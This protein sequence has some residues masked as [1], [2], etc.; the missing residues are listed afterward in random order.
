M[1]KGRKIF[2]I[3]EAVLAVMV[4]LVAF[5]MLWERRGRNLDKISV[6]VENSDDTQWSAFKYGLRM[7]AEDNG[8][9][10]FFVSTG[11]ELTVEE[12]QQMIQT[13]IDNGADAVIVQP[14]PGAEEMLLKMER[15]IPVMLVGYAP[16]GTGASEFPAVGPD[17]YA[18][19]AA[20][21]EELLKDYEE[22]LEGRTLGLLL[23]STDSQAILDREQGFRDV[24]EKAG[25]SVVWSMESSALGESAEVIAAQ[26][27]VDCVAALDD[28]SLT[29]AGAYSSSNVLQEARVYGIGHSTEAAYYLD[30]GAVN[31][32]IVPDEF[33]VGYQSLTE[34]AKNLRELWYRMRGTTVSY[35]AIRREELF[36]KE[37]QEILFT[38]SQ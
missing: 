10:M 30:T 22:S 1:K 16:D 11:E 29:A 25:A 7:A 3:T 23:E 34:S 33:N 8:V 15:K 20:L 21:A 9:E 24:A 17:N 35:K 13:E 26:P 14:I 38:M 12:Q 2:I 4:F 27:K 19:G 6:I 37:N 5:A 18:M 32:L 36:T 28:A 31:C